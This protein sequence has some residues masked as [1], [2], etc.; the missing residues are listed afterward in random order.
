MNPIV[1]YFIT[2]FL[3][4]LLACSKKSNILEEN[5]TQTNNIV[6]ASSKYD[7]SNYRDS[8]S[9][10][11]N[12]KED[13]DTTIFIQFGWLQWQLP[14]DDILKI[15]GLPDSLTQLIGDEVRGGYKK[16]WVYSQMGIKIGLGQEK[17]EGNSTIYF[18]WLDESCKLRSK[19]GIGI[20]SNA[21]DVFRVYHNKIDTSNTVLNKR[22]IVGDIYEGTQFIIQNDTVN[23]IYVG[24]GAE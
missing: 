5:L 9:Q 14:E 3:L 19:N 11:P 2:F 7:T 17:L 22:I 23:K 8:N 10:S 12:I 1:F 6:L 16:E 24:P 20:G 21:K 13:S 15:A 18:Y 4:P